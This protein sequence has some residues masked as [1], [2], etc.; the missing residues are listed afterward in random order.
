MKFV[1]RLQNSHGH[2]N[3]FARRNN[4]FVGA[5]FCRPLSCAARHMP[6]DRNWIIWLFHFRKYYLF[7]YYAGVMRAAECLPYIIWVETVTSISMPETYPTELILLV[8]T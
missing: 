3:A 8:V 7:L 2:E 5:A 1:A 6:N 4:Q